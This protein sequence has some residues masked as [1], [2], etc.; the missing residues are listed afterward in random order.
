MKYQ[1]EL[2]VQKKARL[3]GKNQ[4]QSIP[5][6]F[7]NSTIAFVMVLA[8]FL[9]QDALVVRGFLSLG[10]ITCFLLL[11]CNLTVIYLWPRLIAFSWSNRLLFFLTVI[12]W[13]WVSIIISELYLGPLH[14]ASWFVLGLVCFAVWTVSRGD[15]NKWASTLVFSMFG[16][17][18]MGAVIWRGLDDWSMSTSAKVRK[19][20]DAVTRTEQNVGGLFARAVGPVPTRTS[21]A[22]TKPEWTYSGETGPAMWGHLVEDFKSCRDG[23]AQSP[24][25]IPKHTPL[26]RG[27]SRPNFGEETIRFEGSDSAPRW[28]LSGKSQL[29]IA[30]D[31][32]LS[33][34]ML[35]HTP[36]EH[37]FSGLSFPLEVQ[38]FFEN[39]RGDIQALAIFVEIG[40]ANGAFEALISS[41]KSKNDETLPGALT[42]AMS[43]L[44]PIDISAHR[45]KGSWTTPPC[46][47]GVSWSVV[48]NPIEISIDQLAALRRSF[49]SSARPVQ[50]LGER[51]FEAPIEALSH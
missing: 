14:F 8:G 42:V 16:I 47:E 45:Y 2:A 15:A 21:S 20:T 5:Y 10:A 48:R 31:I 18:S 38:I 35:L 1:R 11:T 27:W 9:A 33:K 44:V 51:K 41:L 3:I 29:K 6:A 24:V 36:S 7:V 28:L 23:K 34:Q 49:P 43:E 30:G 12:E 40:R 39:K 46:E 19:V 50:A 26:I 22:V 37:Q 25:D 32:F 17:I 13:S 4:S